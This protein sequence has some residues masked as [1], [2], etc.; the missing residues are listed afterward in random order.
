MIRPYLELADGDIEIGTN[1]LFQNA[2]SAIHVDEKVVI[3][4]EETLDMVILDDPFHVIQNQFRR[5]GPP[6][7]LVHHRIPTKAAAICTSPTGVKA[8]VV[9]TK[10]AASVV[11]H[12][13]EVIGQG[14]IGIEINERARTGVMDLAVLSV[15]DSLHVMERTSIL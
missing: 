13:D 4:K 12:I 9:D 11:I 5:H 8:Y 3:R 14:R 2:V 15:T 10:E 1:D 6:L 7:P